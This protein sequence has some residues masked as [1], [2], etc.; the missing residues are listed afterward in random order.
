MHVHSGEKLICVND[1]ASN[2]VELVGS[3]LTCVY[4]AEINPIYVNNVANHSL[5]LLTK[6]SL[7]I[8]MP[9]QGGDRHHVCEQCGIPY[10]GAGSLNSHMCVHIGD[11]LHVCD[12]CGK[13]YSRATDQ[14]KHNNIH[15]VNIVA[16]FAQNL[17]I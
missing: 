11:R 7:I 2:S 1:V 6:G 13:S 5:K 3:T 16:I 17:T 14:R 10:S 12:Q 9:V 8:S 15:G 4:T